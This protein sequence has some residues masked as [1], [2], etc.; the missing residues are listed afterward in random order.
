[1]KFSH[2]KCCRI[3]RGKTILRWTAYSGES[4]RVREFLNTKLRHTSIHRNSV[5]SHLF[6]VVLQ[7][8]FVPVLRCAGSGI[9]E[10]GAEILSVCN[11]VYAQIP[12][13]TKDSRQWS[14]WS[15]LPLINPFIPIRG[16]A[17]NI[18]REI[19]NAAAEGACK[20]GAL[21]KSRA[22]ALHVWIRWKRIKII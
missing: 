6:F 17:G 2:F 22:R 7:R 20:V 11:R 4:R 5:S 14:R 9:R 15:L 16:N 18:I 1:M 21:L 13:M 12:F 8:S 10:I 19:L 3:V